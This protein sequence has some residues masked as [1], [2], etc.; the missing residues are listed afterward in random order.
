MSC[1]RE[2]QIGA[3]INNGNR[4]RDSRPVG[5]NL[6]SEIHMNEQHAP[7][8]AIE[9]Q[10]ATPQGPFVGNFELT[11]KVSEVIDT[12]RNKL[13]L[14]KDASFELWYGDK[15]LE[16]EERPLVSF[17]LPNPAQLTLVATGSGV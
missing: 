6:E 10:I 14:P 1:R 7:N 12:V 5:Q 3:S 2:R 8:K 11:A 16:P 17:H 15:R 4:S 13:G 9:L